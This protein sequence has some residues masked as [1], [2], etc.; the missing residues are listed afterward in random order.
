MATGLPL[1]R[2]IPLAVDVTMVGVLHCDGQP[3]RK[4]DVEAGVCL[5]R[6]EEAKQ[7]TYPELARSTDVRLTTLACE[8]GGRWSEDCS[9]LVKQLLKVRV[10]QAP[11]LFRTSAA[12][13][14]KRRWWSLLSV[15]V[16]SSLAASLVEPSQRQQAFVG[17]ADAPPLAKVLRLAD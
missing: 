14:W 4:A 10:A 3:W 6:G 9:W 15:A 8:V 17:G 7:T 16:Q 2:G 1:H 5:L 11:R 13:A 12:Q